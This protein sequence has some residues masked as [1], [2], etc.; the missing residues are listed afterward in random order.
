MSTNVLPLGR[1]HRSQVLPGPLPPVAEVLNHSPLIDIVPE[2]AYGVEECLVAAGCDVSWLAKEFFCRGWMSVHNV[3]DGS[4][5][6]TGRNQHNASYSAAVLEPGD[7]RLS[8]TYESMGISAMHVTCPHPRMKPN[9]VGITP[10]WRVF[11]HEAL[12]PRALT[13]YCTRESRAAIVGHFPK[14]RL[15]YRPSASSR[16][17]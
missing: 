2:A 15:R 8:A 3:A 11:L 16:H 5:L 12:I 10:Q 6:F 9:R 7:H 4:W 1:F 13:E 17:Q 14:G